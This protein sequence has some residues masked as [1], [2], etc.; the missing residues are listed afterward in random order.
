MKKALKYIGIGILIAISS[1]FIMGLLHPDGEYTT[2]I[3]I[4]A[5]IEK[6][7][8]VFNDTTRMRE[9]MP[10]MVLMQNISGAEN[11]VGSKWKTIFRDHERDIE[12]TETVTG[13]K[14]NELFAF[15]LQNEVMN[16]D[17]EIRFAAVGNTTEI[18]AHTKYRGGNIFWRSMFV[19]FEGSMKQQQQEMYA[20]LK[21]VIEK[22]N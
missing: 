18:K 16:S 5:P 19:F 20:M 11:E 7:F 6:T 10:E 14:T 3:V 13:F 17:N 15:N 21:E 2:T 12:M 22:N 9:W 4:N 1:F 8:S